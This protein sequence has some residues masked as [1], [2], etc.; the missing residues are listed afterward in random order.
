M[1]HF[2]QI[3]L[4][5]CFNRDILPKIDELAV[6]QGK[7]RSDVIRDILYAKFSY[8]AVP[9]SQDQTNEDCIEERQEEEK[10]KDC[11]LVRVDEEYRHMFFKYILEKPGR[12]DHKYRRSLNEILYNYFDMAI[13]RVL[14]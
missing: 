13:P 5:K 1:T 3:K 14:H 8:T 9:R 2:L 10:I 6:E 7:T 12:L 4:Y 11:I